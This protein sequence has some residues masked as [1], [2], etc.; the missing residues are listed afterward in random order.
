MRGERIA[1]MARKSPGST[2]AIQGTAVICRKFSGAGRQSAALRLYA[3][4]KKVF[5]SC[6]VFRLANR[7]DSAALRQ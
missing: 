4:F 5:S 7:N 2:V 1:E 6:R 3:F